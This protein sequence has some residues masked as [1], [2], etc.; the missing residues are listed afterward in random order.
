MRLFLGKFRLVPA[1]EIRENIYRIQTE[2]IMGGK[3]WSAAGIIIVEL[4]EALRD[5]GYALPNPR[6]TRQSHAF[7][8]RPQDMK[9]WTNPIHHRFRRLECSVGQDCRDALLDYIKKQKGKPF[10]EVVHNLLVSRLG[11]RPPG[12]M[13]QQRS[14][15]PERVR[16][17]ATPETAVN[18]DFSQ[19][20]IQLC[21]EREARDIWHK[22]GGPKP[23]C[24]V[25]DHLGRH[26]GQFDPD[27][28]AQNKNAFVGRAK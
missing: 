8:M 15:T 7:I 27:K 28:V 19:L 25:D 9:M 20:F 5:L 13:F 26:R 3:V 22:K 21:K 11:M 24:T 1:D 10:T 18:K 16:T 2:T 4:T 17:R 14:Y 6:L 12:Y 23:S